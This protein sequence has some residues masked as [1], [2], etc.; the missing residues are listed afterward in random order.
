MKPA[1]VLVAAVLAAVIPALAPPPEAS[2]ATPQTAAEN[3]NNLKQIG[4][5]FHNYESNNGRFPAGAISDKDGKPL[6]SWRVAILPY[7]E[8]NGLYQQFKLDEPWDGPNNKKLLDKM[9]AVYG[10]GEG[11]KTNYRV[12]TGPGT[13]FDG[14]QGLRFINITDGT[15]NTILAVEAAEAVPW[16]KPEELPYNEKEPLPKLGAGKTGFAVLMCDGSVRDF[17]ADYDMQQMRHAILRADGNV[18][19]FSK[20]DR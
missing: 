20:L 18:V 15:S 5:A 16:T 19:D 6:L 10:A 8:Q 17:R 1:L 9:P 14:K 12:F 13:V 3:R 4:I 2:A 7:L 11:G